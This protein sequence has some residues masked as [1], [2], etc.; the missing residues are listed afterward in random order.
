MSPSEHCA[1]NFLPGAAV[2][3]NSFGLDVVPSGLKGYVF[4]FEN[5]K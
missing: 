3:R 1:F 5:P 4:I 2:K